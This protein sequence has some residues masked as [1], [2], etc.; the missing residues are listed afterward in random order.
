[1]AEAFLRASRVI[2]KEN[3]AAMTGTTLK[4]LLWLVLF[5]FLSLSCGLSLGL[6][7]ASAQIT[8]DDTLGTESSQITT[9]NDFRELI[10][11][12]AIRGSSL[13]HSFE[14]F[15]IGEGQE[16]YFANPAGIN[17]ILGRVT[18]N[19][20]SAIFGTLGVEGMAN[21]FLINPNG[22]IFGPNAQL[23]IGG[24]FVASTA[25]SFTFPGGN[26][27]SAVNPEAPPLLTINVTPGL[28]W[29][30]NQPKTTITNRG[31]LAVGQDLTLAA[32]N[33]DL[34]GQLVAGRDLTLQATDTLKIRDSFTSPFIASSSGKLLVKGI[35]K[36]DIF[37]LNHPQSGLF[38]VEDIVLR[39]GNPII[40][41]AHFYANGNLRTEQLDGRPQVF[42]SPTDPIIFTG[43]NVELGDYRGASL[44][45]LAGGSVTLGNVTIDNTGPI[46]STINPNNTTAINGNL[47]YADL[48]NFEVPDYQVTV[49]PDGTVSRVPIQRMISIDGNNQATLDVR[50]GVDWVSLGGLPINPV[51][52]GDVNSEP[53][54]SNPALSPSI[55][56]NG[57]VR[58]EEP[59]GRVILTNQFQPNDNLAGGVIETNGVNTGTL[60]NDTNG[61]DIYI[62]SRGDIIANGDLST[63]SDLPSRNF[64]GSAGSGGNIVLFS[65]FGDITIKGNLNSQAE[66]FLGSAGSGGLVMV[67]S[68]SGE[69]NVRGIDASS[70]SVGS[71]AG[72]GGDII[73]SSQSGN[74]NANLTSSGGVRTFSLS[75]LGSDSGEASSGGRII[76]FSQSGDITTDDA[77]IS[78]ASVMRDGNAGS[79]GVVILSSQS[80][81]ITVNDLVNASSS[82]RL[83]I[84]KAGQGGAITLSSLSGN[85]TTNGRLISSSDSSSGNAAN[86][87]NITISSQFGNIIVNSSITST[88]S[89]S[90]GNA[91]SGGNIIL[92]T[93]SGDITT[94]DSLTSVSSS[95]SGNAGLGGN[96]MLSSQSGDITINESLESF[97][98]AEFGDAEPGGNISIA[99]PFGSIV[100]NTTQLTSISIAGE[101]RKAKA[102][103]SFTLEARD[104]ISG[105]TGQTLSSTDQSGATEILGF[106]DLLVRDTSVVTS[107]QV[108]VPIEFNSEGIPIR[109][110]ILSPDSFGL[111]G[112]VIITSIGHLTFNNVQVLSD[113]NGTNPAGNIDISS[114]G[115]ITFNNSVINSNTNSTGQAGSIDVEAGQ[116]LRL[117]GATSQLLAQTSNQGRA[118]S[119]SVNAPQ[120][121]VEND[122]LISTST[123]DQGLAGD[124]DIFT[125]TLTMRNGGEIL[126][127]TSGAGDSGTINITATNA[128]LLGEGVQDSSSIISVETSDAGR[129]GNIIIN[130]PN[131]VLSETARITAT[132][133]ENATNLEGGGSIT[134][135]A[136]QMNLAGVVGIFAETQS[137]S[138]GGILTLQPYQSNSNLDV[139][140]APG[141]MISTSTSGSGIGG[142]LRLFA[143]ESIT[144][145]GPNNGRARLASETTS[146]GL[147]GKVRIDTDNLT[148]TGGITLSAE[149]TQTA[150]GD[151]GGIEIDVDNFA[152]R[153]NA[154]VSVRSFGT[155]AAGNLDV[156]ARHVSLNNNASLT[157]E[158]E[159]GQGGDITLRELETLDVTNSRI[160]AQTQTGRAGNLSIFASDSIHLRDSAA[161]SVE[162][163]GKGNP[164]QI[165]TAGNLIL[166]TNELIVE[167]VSS[168]TVS[169]PLG[170][171]GN[172]NIDANRIEL[173]SGSI[174]AETGVNAGSEQEA[175]NINLNGVEFLFLRNG[176]LIAA[177]ANAQANGG[178]V[179]INAEDGFIIAS[180]SGNNDIIATAVEG[181]GGNI[182]I[183]AI[184][185]FGLEERSGSFDQLRSNDSND[186]SASSEFGIDGVITIEDLGIDPAQGAVQLPTDTE[187]SPLSEG[188]QP[189]IDGRGRFVNT[190]RGGIPP[191]PSDPISSSV[192]WEDVQPATSFDDEQSE[193]TTSPEVIVE[194]QGWYVSEQGQVVL[195]AN[196]PSTS[197]VFN[198]QSH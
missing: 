171:A 146:S 47:T 193:E 92:S 16:A 130:T 36:V 160:S 24:S 114:P 158:T 77:L 177:Q 141:A 161:L 152:I 172:I 57:T 136:N 119:I 144:I 138:P 52:I 143:P 133:R 23:D 99:A 39:S 66:A 106:G 113:A 90:S 96:I 174:S 85:I 153:D 178:N 41:D 128:V 76:L 173:N 109:T 75:R 54:Y 111:S 140:F 45:I 132:A 156:Q 13:F 148:L 19:D 139:R 163:Q 29:G 104:V 83:G 134:I 18:G 11:G 82:S 112:N 34:Q 84:G 30:A 195:Y 167:N 131:F 51:E 98:F 145:T 28:Q 74:I 159:A 46:A 183:S 27:F 126:A 118:G 78:V 1:M 97:S 117:T 175:A 26:E 50:S 182:Q 151:A 70:R 179:T 40:G 32:G 124:I 164:F 86:A 53:I 69:I 4:S 169:S 105:L 137:Q 21:L 168:V 67:S 49:N 155:S 65:Q 59:D 121:I 107:A 72:S 56:I 61:G 186:I 48:A 43:G 157:A 3:T 154:Q 101:G 55:L 189:G 64:R 120:V 197:T 187:N 110:I 15:N 115:W 108:E 63:F 20:I 142:D 188:C 185:L 71:R 6:Q 122:A 17:N 147:A 135:N 162:A 73:I 127:F 95:S 38:S 42:I 25:N 198:C 8:P 94:N 14:Q 7:K 181:N 60:L 88:S 150:T 62:H 184:R 123:T 37:V 12:G 31:N 194:A 149:S 58:I 176:S 91:G 89:S 191:S 103:G 93:L 44:H 10:E 166:G 100:G 79:A 102:G 165:P 129:S 190:E 33:L 68:Q 125:E 192:G 170:Q 180:P 22:M 87:G 81:N 80:G 196:I 5:P 35:Q 116:G 9:V 2:L